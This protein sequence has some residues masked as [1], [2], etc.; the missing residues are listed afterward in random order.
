MPNYL[1]LRSV[2]LNSIH[3]ESKCSVFLIDLIQLSRTCLLLLTRIESAL[4]YLERSE[5]GMCYRPMT[6][7]RTH[8]L[9][10]DYF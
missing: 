4:V 1:R 2:S 5:Y 9:I 6:N 7:V 8:L 3:F 10:P